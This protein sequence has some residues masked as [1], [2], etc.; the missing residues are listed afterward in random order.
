[1]NL[2]LSGGGGIRTH[3]SW[4]GRRFWRPVCLPVSPHPTY[5]YTRGLQKLDEGS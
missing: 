4:E 1:M 2:E 5:C 3:K